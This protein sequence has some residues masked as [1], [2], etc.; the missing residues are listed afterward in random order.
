MIKVLVVD[1]HDLVRIGL[2]KLLAEQNG[3]EV[4]GD[5]RDGEQA[6]I[7]VKELKPDIVLMDIKMPGIGG[8]EATKRLLRQNPFVKIII[9][10]SCE[11]EPF[12]SRLL[13]AGASGFLGKGCHV[14]ELLQAIVLAQSGQRY[15][16]P[17]V[18]Q[19]MALKKIHREMKIHLKNY[20]NENYK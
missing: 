2:V 14:E 16:S 17:I 5:A 6:I 15:I 11:E 19:K 12:P 1:D 3:I 9:V 18:A 13:Q 8:L 7:L 20:L 4:V 10:S